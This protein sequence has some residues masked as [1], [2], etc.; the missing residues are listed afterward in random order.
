[1]FTIHKGNSIRNWRKVPDRTVGWKMLFSRDF[2][3]DSSFL[4]VDRSEIS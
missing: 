4:T 2:L 1:M 3:I